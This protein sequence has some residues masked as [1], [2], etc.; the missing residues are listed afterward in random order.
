MKFK[1][2]Q[3][4]VIVIEDAVAVTQGRRGMRESLWGEEILCL[5]LSGCYIGVY[6]CTNH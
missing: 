6:I 2:K 3:N 4:E 1:N 5:N